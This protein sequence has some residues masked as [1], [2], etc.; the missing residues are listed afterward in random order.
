MINI[1]GFAV[2][3][4]ATVL[5]YRTAKDYDRNPV[6]WA[7]ITFGVGF[8]IQIILPF[9]LFILIA[10]VMIATGSAPTQ[11]QQD[12]PDLAITMG[13]LVLSVV[14]VFLILKHLSKIPEEKPFAAPPEP[15]TDFNQ[16]G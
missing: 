15:P 13:C 8:G 12:I 5:A 1:L 6:V 14:A 11:V 7:S 10:V 4:I 2:L 9:L 16:N 3:I